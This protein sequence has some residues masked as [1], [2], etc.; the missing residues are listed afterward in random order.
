[1]PVQLPNPSLKLR[2]GEWVEVRTAGEILATLDG[3]QSLD[4]L[5]F[6]P[7]MLKYCGRKFRVYKCA[8]KTADTIEMFSIRRLTNTVHLEELRCDGAAHGGCQAGCLLFWKESWLKRADS[9]QPSA[10]K[11]DDGDVP[12]TKGRDSSA[13]MG[14]L[15]QGTRRLSDGGQANVTAARPRKCSKLRRVSGGEN[16]SI[17]AFMCKT[18]LRATSA[19]LTLSVSARWR[20]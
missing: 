10:K 18:S 1:M 12:P 2:V 8:H 5:P 7:E 3:A 16:D 6:M 20:R 15:N 14:I 19:C 13:A 9:D 17:R 11:A 4:H